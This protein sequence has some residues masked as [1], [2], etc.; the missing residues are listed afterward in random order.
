LTLTPLAHKMELQSNGQQ[1]RD[2][3]ECGAPKVQIWNRR[4]Q[5]KLSGKR[6]LPPNEL[7]KI[8]LQAESLYGIPT[9]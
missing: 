8:P 3:A 2:P 1:G 6:T 7:W 5:M 9:V 4:N